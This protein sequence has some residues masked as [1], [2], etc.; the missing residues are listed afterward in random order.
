[1]ATL[2]EYG[3]LLQLGF[4][5]GIGLSIFRAPMDLLS[6]AFERDLS[7]EMNVLEGVQTPKAQTNKS[8]LSDLKLE[9]AQT[10]RT[11]ESFH[12][13]FMIAAIAGALVNWA[14]LASASSKAGRDLSYEEEWAVFFI[15]GP[16]FLL[17]AGLLAVVTVHMLR[18][19][20]NKLRAIR[21]Q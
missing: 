8:A 1:M 4:G 21:S 2:G 10:A 12:L 3:S 11:L 17:I 19:H 7:A 14:L 13:P 9:F 15:A 20:R 5:I 6:L 16:Y 18:P